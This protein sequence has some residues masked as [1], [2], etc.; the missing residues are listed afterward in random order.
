MSKG[1]K[2]RQEDIKKILQNWDLINWSDKPKNKQNGCCG[3]KCHCE[4]NP[5]IITSTDLNN[6]F[7]PK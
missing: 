2:R 1:S 3:G 5:N 4:S 7:N 6:I